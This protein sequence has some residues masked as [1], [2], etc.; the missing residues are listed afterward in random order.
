LAALGAGMLWSRTATTG[1]PQTS[2][3]GALAICRR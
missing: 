3:A 1:W 2:H